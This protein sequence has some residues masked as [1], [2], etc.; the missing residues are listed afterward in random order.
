MTVAVHVGTSGY[1]YPEWRG[2][3]YP[4]DLPAAAMLRFYAAR[5]HTVEINAT[6]YRMPTAK[7]VESWAAMTPPGFVFVLKAPQRITHMRRLRDVDEPLRLFCEVARRLGPKLGPLFFQLPPTFKKDTDR[8]RALLTRIPPD[9]R[10]AVEFRHA[11]WFADDV[12]EALRA[13]DAALCVVD[14]EAGA[15]PDQTTASWGYYRL[16]NVDYADD[17]L[18]AW[19]ATVA[20]PGRR[21]VYC[22][23]KHEESG[24]GPALAARLLSALAAEPG[25]SAFGI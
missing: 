5:F 4:A 25:A 21:D 12:Y 11:S 24:A 18:A 20:R 13:R 15:T 14:T 2:R 19:A 3:F 16:R 22:Y 8:L 1:N 23:F 6:F 7:T 17:A 9:L 10:C